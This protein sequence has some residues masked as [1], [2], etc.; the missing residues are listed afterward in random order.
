[1]FWIVNHKLTTASISGHI[2]LIRRKLGL[3]WRGVMLFIFK[4]FSISVIAFPIAFN[5]L[6][7]WIVEICRKKANEMIEKSEF[8]Q[9][10]FIF[11]TYTRSRESQNPI[12]A[13]SNF[14]KLFFGPIANHYDLILIHRK[15]GGC[16]YNAVQIPTFVSEFTSL[17]RLNAFLY[18]LA[19]LRRGRS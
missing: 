2:H 9:T 16:P 3:D 8:I 6:N 12:W 15:W 19:F 10:L 5:K 18:F 13:V 4:W 1:M 7:S 17:Q 14:W 11:S